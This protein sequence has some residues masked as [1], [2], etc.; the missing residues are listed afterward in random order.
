MFG[1]IMYDIKVI[2]CNYTTAYNYLS[3]TKFKHDARKSYE[4]TGRFCLM[5]YVDGL[6]SGAC[7][8]IGDKNY[9]G[10]LYIS[11][12]YCTIG[13]GYAKML[14]ICFNIGKL[15]NCKM[16]R[17]YKYDEYLEFIDKDNWFNDGKF[18]VK[19]SL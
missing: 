7:I 14:D 12:I 9:A 17:C 5:C 15:M 10:G 18:M 8:V 2:G 4:Q 3:K 19:E 13:E 11:A 1:G 6:F 16:L